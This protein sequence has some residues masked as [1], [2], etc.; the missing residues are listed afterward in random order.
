MKPSL[1]INVISNWVAMAANLIV[2]F[3]LTPYIIRSLGMAQYGIWTLV[4]SIIGY[5]G[6]LDMGITAAIMRYTARYAS[7]KNYKALNENVNTS[8][9]IFCLVGAAVALASLIAGEPLAHFFK[10]EAAEVSSFKHVIWLLGIAAGFMFTGTVLTVVILAHERF[11]I[12]NTIRVLT[13]FLRGGL[14]LIVLY[15]GGGL[16]GLGLVYSG[17]AVFAIAANLVV[18]KMYLKHIKLSIGNINRTSVRA[19]LSFGFFSFII[20]IGIVLRTKLGAVVIGR[21]LDMDMVGI[22]GIAAL[23]FGHLMNL[24]ISCS[25]VT[26]PRLA[27]IAGKDSGKNLGDV[28]LKYSVFVSNFAVGA[29]FVAL[30]LC[31]DFFRLWLPENFKDINTATTV[32]YILL[33]GLAPDLMTDVSSNALQAIKKHPYYA[34]QTI[35]EGTANL[36]VS[37]LLVTKLG[38][39]GVA[40]G[41]AITALIAKVVFQPIYC[42]RVIKLNWFEYMSKVFVKP[43]LLAGSLLVVLGGGKM[44]FDATTYLQLAL[45]GLIVLSL[46]LVAAYVFCFDSENRR[47]IS[48]WL[49]FKISKKAAVAC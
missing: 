6:L 49:K 10:I 32:F 14:S 5:Y 28:V 11:V 24:T 41:T 48:T 2:G 34:Y 33:V 19:L 1:V 17:M 36:L 18:I 8:L 3:L 40:M 15:K 44:L 35:V 20:Q 21:Y 47:I 9:T 12:G 7:Q 46:Y 31:R 13:T 23:L 39:I 26:Q 25:G 43:V 37:I 22:Y 29:G 38:I 4:I 27:A 45:K 30:L 42:C 16:A